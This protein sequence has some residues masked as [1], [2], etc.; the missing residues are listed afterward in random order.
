MRVLLGG[1]LLVHG[2]AH[3]VGFVVPWRI[4]TSSEVPYR[5]TLLGADIGQAGVRALGLAWLLVSVL[6]VVLGASV[7]R[8]GG[9]ALRGHSHTRW[10]LGGSLPAGPSGV[11]AWTLG[12]CRDRCTA[13]AWVV[14]RDLSGSVMQGL[15]LGLATESTVI[16]A[17]DNTDFT[18]S[19]LRCAV[20]LGV[21]RDIRG[22]LA[23]CSVSTEPH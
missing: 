5:T 8:H 22:W 3:L 2:V 17:T 16:P 4:V 10:G 6:F 20:R 7:L 19:R 13:P 21:I 9:V 14:L 18:A 12:Q 1:T 23:V 15:L 11:A